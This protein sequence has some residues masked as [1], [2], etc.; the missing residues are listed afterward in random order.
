MHL[1]KRKDGSAQWLYR[2]TIHRWHRELGLGAF[3]KLSLKIVNAQ[4]NG[5]LFYMRVV[6]PLKEHNK[7]KR[8]GWCWQ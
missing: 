7:Q 4:P 5:V 1:H 8:R 2:Y 6:T 3:R